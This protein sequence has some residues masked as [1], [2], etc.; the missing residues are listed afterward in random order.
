MEQKKYKIISDTTADISPEIA[1]AYDI[2]ILPLTILFGTEMYK[3][4]INLTTDLLYEK[5]QS[6]NIF[7]KTSA[8][9][10]AEYEESFKPWLDKGYDI[11]FMTISSKISS[12]MN[13][14]IQAAKNLNASDRVHVL[15]S[16]NLSAGT[17]M[18]VIKIAEELNSG[19]SLEEVIKHQQERRDRIVGMFA[20]ET[21]LYLYK[22]GRCSTLSYHVGKG[23]KM[24]PIIEL[25][26]GKM[27]VKKLKM[28]KITK[29]LDYMVDCLKDDIKEG[30]P[31]TE[32]YM[33]GSKANPSR[34][35]LIKE[36]SKY[37]DPLCI[38]YKEANSVIATHC[39][40]GTVGF[41]YEKNK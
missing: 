25:K 26:E 27:G 6:T 21:M 39:G 32:I 36:I 7:P 14:A 22:G 10:P 30:Y 3:D 8:T 35:Y 29:A 11:V 19:A 28:G 12:T 34:D 38:S 40:P 9:A 24:K 18:Q 41:F 23:L 16:F 33:V 1:K 4:Q 13:N 37:V 17:G 20:I 15:D 31:I 2:E 5:A